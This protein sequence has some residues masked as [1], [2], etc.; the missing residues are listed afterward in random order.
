[1]AKVLLVEDDLDLS[2]TIR[3]WLES[4]SN[5]VEAV[6]DGGEGLERLRIS[7]YDV[8]ILDWNLPSISGLE[9]LRTF[10]SE[11]GSTPVLM[12][13]GKAGIEDKTAGLDGGADDYLT[14]PFNMRE[15][16]SRV[17]ALIRRT[18]RVPL[19]NVLRV[20]DLVCDPTV[21]RVTK[22]DIDIKIGPRDFALLEF[23]MRHAGTVF[24]SEALIERVWHSES[25]ATG[26]AIKA[27]VKRLRQKIDQDNEESLIENIPRVGY[28][29]RA[30]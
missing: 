1:M 3:Q 25:E 21:H 24:S 27:S 7:D 20:G 19:S 29:M 11:R 12:L 26:E 2:A 17:R 14:K 18:Q 15:L 22:N 16:C 4:E 6:H 30:P 5:M 28:R 8:V 10:R 23:L 13:T 9:I